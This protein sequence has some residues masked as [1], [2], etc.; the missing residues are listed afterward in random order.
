MKK[1]LISITAV[2]C[3]GSLFLAS[4]KLTPSQVIITA[5]ETGL[6]SAVGWVALEN[7][8]TEIKNAV[9]SVLD[10]INEKASMVETGTTYSDVIY[11]EIVKVI[12][13]KIE[14]RYQPICKA[15][16]MAM[17]GQLDLLFS[18]HP[19]WKADQGIALS[20]VKG[21]INGVKKGLSL[22]DSSPVNVQA[23][24]N[25]KNKSSIKTMNIR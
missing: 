20:V 23:R 18:A 6:F 14:S 15:A 13:T 11:P 17:L 21:F 24:Q 9:I 22:S 25:L 1:C 10:V 19:E 8:T 7:P 3:L 2:V 5:E 16:S 12:N 4:C